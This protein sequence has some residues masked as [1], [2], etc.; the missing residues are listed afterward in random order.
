MTLHN[1][2]EILFPQILVEIVLPDDGVVEDVVQGQPVRVFR[3]ELQG[4]TR[5]FANRNNCRPHH[6]ELV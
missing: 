2:L 6:F 1:A 3:H 4:D 5:A